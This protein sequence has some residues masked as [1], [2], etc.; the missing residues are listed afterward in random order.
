MNDLLNHV[1][2]KVGVDLNYD[3]I[4][5]QNGFKFLCLASGGV[6]RDFFALFIDFG[7]KIVNGKPSV[8]K[9]MVIE[10]SIENLPNKL[11][12]FKTDSFEEKEILE[13]YLQFIRQEVIDNKRWNSFLISNSEVLKY[14]QI[15]Q[16][17]K[18]LVDL[19]L[20]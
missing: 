20:L 13:H 15:N 18:E 6:P 5:T 3:E 2:Q 10:T 4:F 19:R 1:N 17:L 11:E 16:A 7:N 14:P 9:P 8:T 12:A